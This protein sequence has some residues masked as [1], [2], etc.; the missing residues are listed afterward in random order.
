MPLGWAWGPRAEQVRRPSDAAMTDKV[1][2]WEIA[3]LRSCHWEKCPWEVATW[4]TVHLTE[5]LRCI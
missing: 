5:Y 3:Q 4:E 1:A 2:S